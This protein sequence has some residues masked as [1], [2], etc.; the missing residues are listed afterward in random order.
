[1]RRA[2]ELF[3]TSNEPVLLTGPAGTGKSLFLS[4]FLRETPTPP[5]VL[6]STGI[7]ALQIGGQTVHSHFRLPPRIITPGDLD[8]SEIMP[9][10]GAGVYLLDEA[11]MLRA[12]VIDAMD[13]RLRRAFGSSRA[14]GGARVLLV[15]DPLQLP[16]VVSKD[17]R[18]AFRAL[19][20]AS[21]WF[22]HARV[23]GQVGLRVAV[24]NQ[25]H[26]Q[27]DPLFAHLLS[28]VRFGHFP[29]PD[30]RTL[31]DLVRPIDH[32]SEGFVLTLTPTRR[33]AKDENAARLDA[34]DGPEFIYR[35]W[36]E[37]SFPS[38]DMP[39]PQT[40]VLKPQARVVFVKNDPFRR[41]VNGSQG[42]IVQCGRREIVVRIDGQDGEHIV[43]PMTW[44][45]MRQ[46][47]D[48]GAGCIV[49]HVVGRYT[50]IPCLLGWAMT[51]HRSQGM[52][53][54]RLRVDLGNG[55][56][57]GGQTYVALSRVRSSGGLELVRP[58][59][60]RDVWANS[61]VTEFLGRAGAEGQ[62]NDA[63]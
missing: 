11:S 32:G 38:R 21:P 53:L 37:G 4:L 9:L 52:T 49:N 12:D 61:V 6:A 36:V 30:R 60:R 15:G 23:F 8:N 3:T 26:R 17:E 33:A 31:A 54:D 51:I 16:P 45:K 5:V 20:Y 24:L 40:L 44:E 7:S 47:Y 43:Q 48:R 13:V 58:V 14:F 57:E 35:G 22:F 62:I 59:W 29:W 34:L 28:R 50:Q 55:A 18:D 42:T 27:Q 1:V 63:A 25:I 39:V 19:G 56:F 41:W 2:W 10:R 46:Q